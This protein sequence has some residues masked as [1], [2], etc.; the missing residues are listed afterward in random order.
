MCKVFSKLSREISAANQKKADI[1][2][3]TSSVVDQINKDTN[4]FLELSEQCT[5]NDKKRIGKLS[6]KIE[7]S[8]DENDFTSI[9]SQIHDMMSILEE[10]KEQLIKQK[11]ADSK[12]KSANL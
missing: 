2:N 9:D 5:E 1:E 3:I 12:L 4:E 11:I 6:E 7:V 8:I 10:D